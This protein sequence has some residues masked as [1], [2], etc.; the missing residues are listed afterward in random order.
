MDP[1][2]A[3]KISGHHRVDAPEVLQA[4]R[5]IW[6]VGGQEM[7]V[8]VDQ[9][10]GELMACTYEGEHLDPCSVVTAGIQLR[11]FQRVFS[12]KLTP[13]DGNPTPGSGPA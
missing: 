6:E 13:T 1:S 5:G 10:T 11:P 8:E 9:E 2:H 12:G 3:P 7:V 4:L